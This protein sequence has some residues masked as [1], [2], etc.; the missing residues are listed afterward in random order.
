MNGGGRP[1]LGSLG[2][3]CCPGGLMRLWGCTPLDRRPNG[4]IRVPSSWIYLLNGGCPW[5]AYPG[6]RVPMASAGVHNGQGQWKA[7][8]W[9][10]LEGV[11]RGHDRCACQLVAMAD[12]LLSRLVDGSVAFNW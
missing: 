6:T 10:A 11:Y 5:P 1:G 2:R 12:D 9:P 8:C 7:R 4:W 3:W